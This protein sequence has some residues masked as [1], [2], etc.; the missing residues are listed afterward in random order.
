MTNEKDAFLRELEKAIRHHPNKVAI[1][2]E[3]ETH[4]QE[5]LNEGRF[6]EHHAYQ[7]LVD[8]LGT[9]K[10]IADAWKADAQLT[11][12]KMQWLF[13]LL[14]V[15]LFIGGGL[16]TLSYNVFHWQWISIIWSI[17][18]DMASIV[19]TIYILFWG[20]LGY[21]IGR[22]FGH[23]GRKLLKRTFLLSIVP[24]VIFMYLIIFKVIPHNWF[25][26]L[27]NVSF[28]LLCVV[29]TAGLYPVSLLG[30][31]WGKKASVS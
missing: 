22:E 17:L 2:K 29:L 27:L 13:V 30:Y 7:F 26:P 16:L 19:M 24:N 5:A 10:E 8:T 9:P 3:Y 4:V 6:D 23:S 11:P 18:T 31:K 1:M 25:E 21:E 12:R 14:N 28:I 15:A 20:L